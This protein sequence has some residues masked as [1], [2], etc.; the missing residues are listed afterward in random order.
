MS[1]T[2]E[3][4]PKSRGRGP[5]HGSPL[6][7]GCSLN[8][9]LAKGGWD[10]GLIPSPSTPN[11]FAKGA[12]CPWTKFHYKYDSK[13]SKMLMNIEPNLFHY[14]SILYQDIEQYYAWHNY[15]NGFF[16]HSKNS[17]WMVNTMNDNKITLKILSKNNCQTNSHQQ[18]CCK[19]LG[20]F[21]PHTGC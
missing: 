8:C 17:E 12:S 20:H 19:T 18:S 1:P 11:K 16:S 7:S 15:N 13:L 2:S 10:G 14:N 3:C 9:S 4:A 5:H 21:V 6:A